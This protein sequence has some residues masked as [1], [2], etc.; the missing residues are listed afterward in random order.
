M[1]LT[2]TDKYTY[3]LLQSHTWEKNYKKPVIF[4]LVQ[5]DLKI[6]MKQQGMAN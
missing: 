1:G 3:S 6:K 4:M 5:V 2:E